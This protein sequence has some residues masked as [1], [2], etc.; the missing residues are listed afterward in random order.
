ME[1][2][3]SWF[4][5]WPP[6]L[7]IAVSAARIASKTIIQ[8]MDKLDS[9]GVTE[10]AANDFVTQVDMH[11]EQQIIEKIRTAYP[12]HTIIGEESGQSGKDAEHVWYIDPIDGTTNYIHGFPQFSVSIAFEHRGTLQN[13][14]VFDPIRNELFTATRGDGAHLNEK[15]MRVSKAKKLEG[16]LIGTGFPFKQPQH[17]KTFLKTFNAIFPETSG[18]RRAGSAALDLAYVA[19]GRL[20]GF[21]EMSLKKWDMA[22]GVLL[23]KEAGGLLSDFHGEENYFDSGN[24]IAGNPKILKALLKIIQPI[25]AE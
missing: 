3:Q 20:D 25:L 17:L 16:T 23:I 21:W 24:V 18:V 1:S 5:Y 14:I 13:A 10:K 11:A 22:A 7:Y 12:D 6:M 15:R 8:S 2:W 4:H 9:L 19:A